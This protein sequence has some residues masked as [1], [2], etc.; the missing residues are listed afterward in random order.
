MRATGPWA[1]WWRYWY[2]GLR[3]IE[4]P[5]TW[6]TLQRGFGNLAVIHIVGRRSG[7]TRTL[8]LGLLS[9]DGRQYLGHPSGD[10]GWTLDLRAADTA[11][12]ERAGDPSTSVRTTVLG[13]GAERDAVIRASFRQHHF[14]G[15]AFYRL[16]ASHVRTTG[17][18]FRLGPG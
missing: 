12:L 17:V 10:C 11:I 1:S 3:L 4:R 16:A 14:P 5:L 8:P 13:P 2:R 18:F 15:N 7:R 6:W 9:V